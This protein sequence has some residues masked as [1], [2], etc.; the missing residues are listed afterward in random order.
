LAL[1]SLIVAMLSAFCDLLAVVVLPERRC[2]Q[3]WRGLVLSAA[4]LL[5]GH[6]CMLPA[7]G[8][9]AR[10]A[11]EQNESESTPIEE[12]AKKSVS[13][14]VECLRAARRVRGRLWRGY[15]FESARNRRPDARFDGSRVRSGCLHELAFQGLGCPLRC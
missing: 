13:G 5:L 2:S 9:I 1:V 15:A 8:Q 12:N 3:L 7:F 10:M 6:S 14:S 4:V 11:S